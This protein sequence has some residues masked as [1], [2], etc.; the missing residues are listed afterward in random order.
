MSRDYDVIVVG[1]GP[2]GSMAARSAASAGAKTLLLE[3]DSHIGLPVR[4]GEGVTITNVRKLVDVDEKMIASH[5]QGLV[6]HA[7]DDTEVEVPI[8]DVGVILERAIFDRYLA[9]LAASAGADVMTRSDVTGLIQENGCVKGV[10]Y[11]RLGKEYKVNCGV[12]IGADGVESRVGKWAGIKTKLKPFD[13]ESAY[14]MVLTGR[15][16]DSEFCHFWVGNDIAPGGYIWAFP[17]GSRTANVGIGVKAS[18]GSPGAAYDKLTALIRR[19][20]G[21][22]V[23]TGESAGGVPCGP[24]LKEPYT[25]GL[26]LVGDAARHCNPLTGGGIFSG[27]VSGNEAGEVAAIAVSKGDVSKNRLSLFTKRIDKSINRT[28]KRAYRLS[29]AVVKLDDATLNNTAHEMIKIPVEKRN[30]K[31]VFLRALISYPSLAVDV[32]KAFV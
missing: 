9:E 3:R 16:F 23:I 17:K 14:Q 19:Y 2:A 10:V 20:F 6:I 29:K 11:E 22:I 8:S 18:L 1:G 30:L 7:P 31:N 4:C 15:N 5:L 26:L 32:V 28:H 21:N 24:P 12:V 25:D 27:M 13:I